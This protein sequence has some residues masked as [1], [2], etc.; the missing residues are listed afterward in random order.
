MLQHM[1]IVSFYCFIV[2]HWG[3]TADSVY[4]VTR[5]WIFGVFHCGAVMH[6]AV[7]NFHMQ[8]FVRTCGISLGQTRRNGI[9]GLY[10][11]KLLFNFSGNGPTGFQSGCI[12]S[13]FHQHI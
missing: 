10:A 3:D 13:Y 5:R 2:F 8:V 7:K 1:S 6:R 12:I 4:S 9:A 11:C